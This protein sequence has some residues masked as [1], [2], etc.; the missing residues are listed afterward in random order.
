ME[1][2]ERKMAIKIVAA[3]MRCIFSLETPRIFSFS[4]VGVARNLEDRTLNRR[5]VKHEL[6]ALP[7]YKLLTTNSALSLMA[8]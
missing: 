3:I 8:L 6:V 4:L 5:R 2:A 1:T 7:T